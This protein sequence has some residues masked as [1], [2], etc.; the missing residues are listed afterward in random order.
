MLRS[1]FGEPDRVDDGLLL[2]VFQAMSAFANRQERRAERLRGASSKRRNWQL[3]AKAL[4]TSLDE[5]EQSQYCS[6]RFQM[7]V[8]HRF[9]NE[10]NKHELDDYYRHVYFFKNA[11]IRVFSTL[12]KL[13]Y[14]MNEYF[15]LQTQR[16][17]Q[18]FS[19]F[20]VIRRMHVRKS[21]VRL[22]QRL[23]D[24]KVKYQEPLYR[25]RT[26]RNTEIHWMNSELQDDLKLITTVDFDTQHIENLKQNRA[27][28]DQSVE[29]VCLTLKAAFQY[30]NRNENA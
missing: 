5:L 11:I 4:H 16:E 25:L 24:L 22:E 1:L 20:T 28:L 26:L 21:H 3:W 13:G 27:D 6:N 12:D 8:M 10:M 19:Y 14:F 9:E 2:E 30:M 29:L 7:N 23:Y 17:K 15:R 18:R